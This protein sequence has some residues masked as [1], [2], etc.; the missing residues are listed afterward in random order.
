MKRDTLSAI[1][2]STLVWLVGF[3]TVA[4][5]KE[6]GKTDTAIFSICRV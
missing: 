4:A 2:A 3:P 1:A 6:P 5:N